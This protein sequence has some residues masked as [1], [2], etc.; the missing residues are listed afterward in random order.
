ML[1]LGLNAHEIFLVLKKILYF[2]LH[3]ILWFRMGLESFNRFY[4]ALVWPKD[5]DQDRT[6]EDVDYDAIVFSMLELVGKHV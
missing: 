6:F 3:D 1:V 4:W 2:I 5:I